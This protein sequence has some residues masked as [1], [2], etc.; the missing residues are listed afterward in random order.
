MQGTSRPNIGRMAQALEGQR[1]EW[2][3][4]FRTGPWT[5]SGSRSELRLWSGLRGLNHD[6][7][8]VDD[9]DRF[10]LRLRSVVQHD[11]AVRARHSHRVRT[12]RDGLL[13]SLQVDALPESLLHP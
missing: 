8:H 11:Q 1:S 10:A 4:T 5:P 7:G 3:E 2:G 13:G 6:V 9:L 12:G